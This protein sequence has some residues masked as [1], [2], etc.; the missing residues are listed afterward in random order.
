[1]NRLTELNASI[2][3]DPKIIATLPIADVDMLLDDMGVDLTPF[4]EKEL[5]FI[6]SIKAK[7][8]QQEDDNATNLFNGVTDKATDLL[9][10]F[11]Q[12][13]ITLRMPQ[14]EAAGG[15]GSPA[16]GGKETEKSILSLPMEED[17]SLSNETE[18]SSLMVY[19][20]DEGWMLSFR[21]MQPELAGKSVLLVI[22][23]SMGKVVTTETKQL[24]EDDEVWEFEYAFPEDINLGQSLL[25][26]IRAT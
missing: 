10:Q 16:A 11:T 12:L 22:T 1:M 2:D 4:I 20:G 15:R 8:Q 21:T 26:D 18:D 7:W 17:E 3:N 19:Q 5:N 9:N 14:L 23:D 13:I 25:I 6:N 24:E